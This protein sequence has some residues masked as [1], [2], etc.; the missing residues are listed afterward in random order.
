MQISVLKFG[1]IWLD[2]LM[3]SFTYPQKFF[4]ISLSWSI[5]FI[6]SLRQF[7][8]SLL[9]FVSNKPYSNHIFIRIVMFESFQLF[10]Q[11]GF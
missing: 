3:N 11:L 6:L 4:L 1:R 7:V 9:T 8:F 5:E 2:F 10:L